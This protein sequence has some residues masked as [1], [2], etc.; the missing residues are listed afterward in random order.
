MRKLDSVTPERKHFFLV[1]TLRFC[2]LENDEL[3]DTSLAISVM[4]VNYL[5][6]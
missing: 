6:K 3:Q 2:A 1:K 4:L 5:I